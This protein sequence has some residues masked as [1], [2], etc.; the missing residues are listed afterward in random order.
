MAGISIAGTEIGIALSIIGLGTS[1]AAAWRPAEWSALLLIGFF[2]LC[3]GYAHG[4]E[5]PLSD[6][7][8]DYAVGFVVAT[9][10]I[11]VIGVGVG[12]VLNKPFDGHV[13]RLLGGIIALCGVYYFVSAIN[14]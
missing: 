4:V 7:P 13:S 8:A 2:A 14:G 1:I 5:L 6:D 3:H 12:L 9:G 10:M 11:H